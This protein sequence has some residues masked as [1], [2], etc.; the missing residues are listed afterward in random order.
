MRI[1]GILHLRTA[2]AVS[3]AVR[4]M[5]ADIRVLR[6]LRRIPRRGNLAVRVA[7][8]N[9]VTDRPATGHDGLRTRVLLV[10]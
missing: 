9:R 4:G 6:R 3:D 7:L 8:G 2:V 5:M 1:A 10:G